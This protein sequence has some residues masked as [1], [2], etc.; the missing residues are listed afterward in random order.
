MTAGAPSTEPLSDAATREAARPMA[1][2]IAVPA[3]RP[4]RGAWLGAVRPGVLLVPAGWAATTIVLFFCYLR[5]SGTTPIDS[6]GG[7]DALQAWEMLHGNLLLHGWQL[8]NVS[9]Y[10]I[11][12]PQYM[13]I[14]LVHGLNAEV[15]HI[16]AAVTYTLLIL[17]AALLAKGTATG[18]QAAVR[19]VIA[20]GIMV[21]P[22]L[23]ASVKTLLLSP[24]HIGSALL[25]LATW[26]LVDR[27]PRRW[28]LPLAVAF[29][30]ALGLI[31]DNTVLMTGV[32]PLLLVCAVR[33]HQARIVNRLPLRSV[34]YELA[35]GA[36]A[37]LA[38]PAARA[39]LMLI[40]AAGG[41]G[42]AQTG[43]ILVPFSDWLPHI[44]DA[45]D[46]LLLLFGADFTGRKLDFSAALTILHLVGLGLAA[47]GVCRAVRRFFCDID[48]V[49]SLLL[50]GVLI[51]LA[52]YLFGWRQATREM[53]A[54]LPLSA[55]LAARM[56][57]ARLDRARLVPALAVVLAG[58]LA[59]LGLAAASAGCPDPGQQLGAFLAA[60]QLR[61]GL[62]GYWQANSVTVA[63]NG[64][65]A[66]RA[67]AGN[68]FLGTG[69]WEANQSWYDPDRHRADFVVL[70]PGADGLSDRPVLAT[71]GR[72]QRSYDDG[73]YT[74]LVWNKNL[75][76]E[77]R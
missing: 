29:L 53:V 65:V 16:G 34:R 69:L 77:L 13:L 56:L 64:R 45:I 9:F 30:L 57:G 75:L 44:M 12:L 6:D 73:A 72:P 43:L 40:S 36:A 21:A 70:A 23:G 14:E 3:Q 1:P 22:E 18:R 20:G 27:A 4:P 50:A 26:L 10:T 24:D 54:V 32:L 28:Y 33:T 51:N 59:S 48:L 38:V 52:G 68:P 7:A 62:A 66:V 39:A 47:W 55:V 15:I 19:M 25:V 2:G 35:L 76:T 58:Y 17:L 8:S 5:V 67:V 37:L 61:Y 11:D 60:H 46:G 74:V 42:I 41:F 31:A 71:F 49:T 63:S